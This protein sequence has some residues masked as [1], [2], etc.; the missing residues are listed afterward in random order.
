MPTEHEPD[1]LVPPTA[2]DLANL[3]RV[4]IY[5]QRPHLVATQKPGASSPRAVRLT[6]RTP[7]AFQLDVSLLV[8]RSLRSAPLQITGEALTTACRLPSLL[9]VLCD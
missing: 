3:M 8:I 6:G 4:L 1:Q 9:L 5:P 2:H 7:E